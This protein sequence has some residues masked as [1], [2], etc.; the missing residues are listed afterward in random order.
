MNEGNKTGGD[1]NHNDTQRDCSN[2]CSKKATNN[3][4]CNSECG[5]CMPNGDCDMK[6]CAYYCTACA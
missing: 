1:G 3:V 6:K 2:V 5:N 4:D